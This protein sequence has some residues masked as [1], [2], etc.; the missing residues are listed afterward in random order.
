MFLKL[1]VGQNFYL[2]SYQFVQRMWYL[3]RY[4]EKVGVYQVYRRGRLK[5]V[6]RDNSGNIF[7]ESVL[8]V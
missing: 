7:Q 2:K 6:S 5:R 4:F 3:D 1:R 8:V